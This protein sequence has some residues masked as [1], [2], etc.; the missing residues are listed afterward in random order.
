MPEKARE[1][2]TRRRGSAAQLR[3]ARCPAAAVQLLVGVAAL[4]DAAALQTDTREQAL[5]LAVAEYARHALQAGCAGC[6]RI[7]SDGPCCYRDIASQ[8]KR[9]RLCK[10]PDRRRIVENEDEVGEL[11]ADLATK[12]ATNCSDG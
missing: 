1:L 11:E 4:D 9:S 3:L 2:R 6:F 10:C 12:A 8:C 7:A 5:G